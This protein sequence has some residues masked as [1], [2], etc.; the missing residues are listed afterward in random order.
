MILLVQRKKRH[1][2]GYFDHEESADYFTFKKVASL[3]QEDC[4]FYASFG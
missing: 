2:I 1:V 3:L 4:K